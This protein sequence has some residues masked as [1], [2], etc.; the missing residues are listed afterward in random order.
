VRRPRDSPGVPGCTRRPFKLPP[1]SSSDTSPDAGTQPG[2][3]ER[4]EAGCAIWASDGEAGPT[5]SRRR[6]AVKRRAAFP[7]DL[8]C[9]EWPAANHPQTPSVPTTRG[10]RTSDAAGTSTH[11]RRRLRAYG[12]APAPL[13]QTIPIAEGAGAEALSGPR[14]REGS[15]LAGKGS[16]GLL[17]PWEASE[18]L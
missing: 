9:Q 1:L 3:S 8:T 7:V 14:C 11:E 5:R 12:R 6:T 16:L 17:R 18:P 4:A 15:S 13:R 10:R 2:R